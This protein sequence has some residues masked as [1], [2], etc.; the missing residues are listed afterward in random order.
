VLTIVENQQKLF[1]LDGSCD[2]FG[3]YDVGFKSQPKRP[4]HR[5]RHEIGVR[6]RRQLDEPPAVGKLV[7][8]TAGDL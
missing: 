6:Q 3:R 5:G 7:E 2:G 4:G 1:S 8:D